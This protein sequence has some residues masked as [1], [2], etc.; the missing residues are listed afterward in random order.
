MGAKLDDKD[1]RKPWDR[2]PGE[3]NKWWIRFE[4]Y[5][6]AG[7][8]RSAFA[9]S[10]RERAKRGMKRSLTLPGD[11]KDH[12]LKY[13]WKERVEAWD[14]SLLDERRQ[15]WADRR[16]EW[17]QQEWDLA[18]NM[19]KKVLDMMVFPIARVTREQDGKVTIIEP[20]E[21]KIADI[22]KMATVISKLARL[23]TGMATERTEEIDFDPSQLT[24]EELEE[25]EE[26]GDVRAVLARHK[27]DQGNGEGEGSASAPLQLPEA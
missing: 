20:A 4:E 24:D 25:I 26:T 13:R 9:Q 23:A 12:M 21:W 1:E 17:R 16:E 3:T 5:R 6:L 11:W 19:H 22:P 27:Q 7:H 14:A 18:E 8:T 10:N 15:E 2:P